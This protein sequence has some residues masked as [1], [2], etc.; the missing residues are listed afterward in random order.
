M[1]FQ[2][3]PKSE[4]PTYEVLV[5]SYLLIARCAVLLTTCTFPPSGDRIWHFTTEC[6]NKYIVAH[7]KTVCT[8][9]AANVTKVRLPGTSFQPFP[10]SVTN[11]T[12]PVYDVVSTF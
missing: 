6:G 10:V 4:S 7:W 9:P 2:K 11:R 1:Y 3:R 12:I 5:F 8:V